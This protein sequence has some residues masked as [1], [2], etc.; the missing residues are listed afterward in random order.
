M[1]TIQSSENV[2][3]L[4]LYDSELVSLLKLGE[5]N[6]NT[7]LRKCG[8]CGG[9]WVGPAIAV[10]LSASSGR[11]TWYRTDTTNVATCTVFSEPPIS[12]G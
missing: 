6:Q 12:V 5:T 9:V 10:Y 4:V 1:K 11:V 3:R 7:Y 2:N 8:V